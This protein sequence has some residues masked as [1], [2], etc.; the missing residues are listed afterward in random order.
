MTEVVIKDRVKEI[1]TTIGTG[2]V[3]LD[4][5][6]QGFQSFA[7]IGNG[8]LTFYTIANASEWEVGIGMYLTSG[9]TLERNVVLDSSS[10]GN[11]VNWVSGEKEVFVTYPSSIADYIPPSSVFEY[12]TQALTGTGALGSVTVLIPSVEYLV[13]AG[14]GGGAGG[15]TGPFDV[16]GAGG[17]AGGFR[18]GTGIL[19]SAGTPYT[20]TVGAG[21]NGGL[22]AKGSPGSNSVFSTITSAGGGGAGFYSATSDGLNGGSGGGGGTPASAGTTS[23]AGNG[24]TPSTSPSQGN[25]GGTGY[26]TG[27]G[28]GA[29]GGGG[30]SA[31]GGSAPN[32]TVAGAGGAGMASSIS[33]SSVTYAGGGGGGSLDVPGTSGTGGAG[34]AGGGGAGVNGVGTANPGTANTGG[35]GGGNARNIGGSGGSGVVIL[36]YSDALTISNPGGGLTYSTD[37]AGGFSVTTFT[38]GTGNVQWSL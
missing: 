16:A 12:L 37:T 36:K 8:N 13:V 21:G 9:P 29:G 31:V 24:N 30:A 18:T 1:S 33:G 23:T 7:A 17:G 15:V 2:S 26:N 10:N 11:K 34:G 4:G 5:A 27:A 22:S 32:S 38:A 35:G 20:V 28:S 3:T 6:V 25:N 14:G 19:L